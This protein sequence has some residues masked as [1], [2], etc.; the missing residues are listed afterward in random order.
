KRS[1]LEPH[2]FSLYIFISII[3]TLLLLQQCGGLLRQIFPVPLRNVAKM[4]IHVS[5]SFNIRTVN[6]TLTTL[7]VV[8]IVRIDLYPFRGSHQR[9]TFCSTDNDFSDMLK[10]VM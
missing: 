10:I 7:T 9:F 3:P 5:S 1:R 2:G 4:T 8:T 6:V